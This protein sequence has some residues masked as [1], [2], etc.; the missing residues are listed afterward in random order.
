MRSW[1]LHDMADKADHFSVFR[2]V[3]PSDFKGVPC[4]VQQQ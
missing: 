1:S 4:L 3:V 2:L